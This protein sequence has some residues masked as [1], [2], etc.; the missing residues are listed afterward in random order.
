MP[1]ATTQ[2]N[3]TAE[4]AAVT[5][6]PA[7]T[8]ETMVEVTIDHKKVSVPLRQALESYQTQTAAR[9]R[10]AEA[11]GLLK[12]RRADIEFSD[13]VKQGLAITPDA[14][15]KQLADYVEKTT[16]RRPILQGVPRSQQDDSLAM[17]GEGA[18]EPHQATGALQRL[19]ATVHELSSKLR[20]FESS[21][22]AD[23]TQSLIRSSVEQFPIFAQKTEQGQRLRDAI[24]MS[25]AGLHSANPDVA[26][27][28]IVAEI[29][30]GLQGVVSAEST[31][32]HGELAQRARTLAGIPSGA[33]TPA[34]TERPQAVTAAE[35][36]KG[37]LRSALHR[38]AAGLQS[39]R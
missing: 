12:S 11:D 36:K 9:N 33:G 22:S 20:A 13:K 18:A 38:F 19:E 29:H 10:L 30:A 39:P 31:R 16:G 34:L 8:P 25:V 23:A 1:E 17:N 4:A 15:L 28:D 3:G 21:T 5:P 14:T 35:A 2:A 37:G 6:A 32:E 26:I 7:P 27:P 24:V